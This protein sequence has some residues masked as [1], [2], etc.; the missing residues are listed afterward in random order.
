MRRTVMFG[1]IAFLLMMAP[2][3]Y[4][5]IAPASA[6]QTRETPVY[7][8]PDDNWAKD[9]SIIK[10]GDTFQGTSDGGKTFQ[11]GLAIHPA[12]PVGLDDGK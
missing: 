6:W 1:G 10:A 8:D 9:P 3:A 7:S 12:R 4:T 5:E 11:I 2:A